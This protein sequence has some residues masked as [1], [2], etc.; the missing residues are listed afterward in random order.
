M[1]GVGWG[2]KGQGRYHTSLNR[3]AT[4]AAQHAQDVYANAWRR[5][6]AKRSAGRVLAA[7]AKSSSWRR[8]L[9][10]L[11]RETGKPASG[12]GHRN[13]RTARLDMARAHIKRLFSLCADGGAKY[14]HPSPSS[15][16]RFLLPSHKAAYLMSPRQRIWR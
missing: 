15:R 10:E 2:V 5:G 13:L 16:S 7:A 14:T 3:A 9:N 4:V 11:R 12:V 1:R 8:R 6:R